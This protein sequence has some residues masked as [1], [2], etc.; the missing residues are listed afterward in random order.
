MIIGNRGLGPRTKDLN[1]LARFAIAG[2]LDEPERHL[3]ALMRS[4]EPIDGET[5]A[6]IAD[7]LEGRHA[8][9]QLKFQD[10]C[11][12]QVL[13]RF[14]KIRS[15]IQI[16]REVRELQN[17]LNYK[18]ATEEV[19]KRRGERRGAKTIEKCVTLSH[20]LDKWIEKARAEGFL[21]SNLALE[22]AFVYQIVGQND[23]DNPIKPS[24]ETLANM[25]ATIDGLEN[26]SRGKPYEL[27]D[28]ILQST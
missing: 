14:R 5:R 4:S 18:D 22:C 12:G 20:K 13:R 6:K 3:A 24:F 23:P 26:Y 21:Y 9:G 16:G 11:K 27:P 2:F 17:D 15:D 25:I 19:S 8:A 1:L 28:S 10:R 7:A